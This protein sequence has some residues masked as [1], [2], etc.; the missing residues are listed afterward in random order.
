MKKI[1]TW[2]VLA[3]ATSLAGCTGAAPAPR[4]NDARCTDSPVSSR[5]SQSLTNGASG[6]RR[7]LVTVSTS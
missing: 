7:R 6:A 4:V 5:C 3:L 1:A 2:T